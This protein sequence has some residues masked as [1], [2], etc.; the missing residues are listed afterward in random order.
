MTDSRTAVGASPV[1]A[2]P[3]DASPVDASPTLHASRGS[4]GNIPAGGPRPRDR[5][6]AGGLIAATR[7][8]RRLPDGVLFRAADCVGRGLYL[9]MPAR[10]AM[11]R[12]NLLRVC[13]WTV[14]AGLASVEVRRA[15]LGGRDLDRL[16]RA[17]FGHWVRTYA[18]SA[19]A[20]RYGP[21]ALRRRIH[22]ETP[23]AMLAAI[24]PE[25][26]DHRGRIFVG[27]HF[28]AVELA[29]LYAARL[30]GVPVGGP[31]ETVENHALRAYFEATRRAFGVELVPV[32]DA[33]RAMRERLARGESVAIVADRQIGGTG[34]RVQLF[35]APARLPLGPAYLAADSDALLYVISVRRVGWARWAARVEPIE[36]RADASRRERLH[37]A[38]HQEARL[39]ERNVALAPEQWWSLFFPIWE[40][41][42]HE[43]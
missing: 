26:S 19:V 34:A 30:G 27:F 7:L 31:M 20:P 15:A 5:L 11:M 16:V 17:A 10:R 9:A 8:L 43:Q 25:P 37:D 39:L 4:T 32:H 28:G 42:K 1:D 38:L 14:D 40:D 22:V 12:E 36:L 13:R 21:T 3:V 6:I 23:E 2:S 33:A 18:E 41:N 29:A 24:L 35:G